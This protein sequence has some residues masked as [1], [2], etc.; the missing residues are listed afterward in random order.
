MTGVAGAA[1]AGAVSVAGPEGPALN[2]AGALSF[3]LGGG[4]LAGL[5]AACLPVEFPEV[6]LS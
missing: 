3:P 5:T 1:L 6:P 4:A 2:P